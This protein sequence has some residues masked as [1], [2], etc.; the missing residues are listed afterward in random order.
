VDDDTDLLSAYPEYITYLML[1]S[2]EPQEL[3][4]GLRSL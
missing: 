3:G 2:E 1:S 4:A